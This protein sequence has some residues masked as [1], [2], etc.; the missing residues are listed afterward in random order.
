[1]P[2]FLVCSSS[3]NKEATFPRKLQTEHPW[4]ESLGRQAVIIKVANFA[5]YTVKTTSE[6]TLY[7]EV[8]LVRYD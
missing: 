2:A 7:W 3:I 8:Y 5:M 6:Y 4:N 1:M